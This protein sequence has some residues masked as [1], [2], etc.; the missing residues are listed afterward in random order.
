MQWDGPVAVAFGEDAGNGCP[1][2]LQALEPA[3]T[4]TAPPA[5]TC[6]CSCGAVTGECSVDISVHLPADTDCSGAGSPFTL[7]ETCLPG[8]PAAANS[9]VNFETPYVAAASCGDPVPTQAFDPPQ[10][11]QVQVCAP[12][13]PTAECEIGHCFPKEVT[14]LAR[15]CIARPGTH[16]CPNG[17]PFTDRQIIGGNVV[18]TRGCPQ[19]ECGTPTTVGCTA[20]VNTFEQAP[21][22]NGD[23]TQPPSGCQL[24]PQVNDNFSALLTDATISGTCNPEDPS[25]TPEGDVIVADP[26]TLCCAP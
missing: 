5:S 24:L 22:G 6:G 8:I 11:T 18:D 23:A 9:H 19:C 20:T 21:C 14:E 10:T 17:L 1:Q 7:T 13:V 15:V 4:I 12:R 26:I 25:P 16:P 3:L 2:T